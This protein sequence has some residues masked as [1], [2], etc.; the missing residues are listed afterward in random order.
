MSP[1][2]ANAAAS[3]ARDAAA[4]AALAQQGWKPVTVWE[5]ELRDPELPTRL[6]QALGPPGA[7]PAAASFSGSRPAQAASTAR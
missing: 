2:A 7:Q 5:C 1:E 6:E 3:W 4:E